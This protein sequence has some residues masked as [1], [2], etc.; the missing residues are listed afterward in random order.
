MAAPTQ[1]GASG[2][3]DGATGKVGGLKDLRAYVERFDKDG[4][5]YYRA[6]FAGFG[7]QKA[8]MTMCSQLKKAKVSCLAMQG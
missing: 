1:N 2:L 3:L 4:Q 8:A 7:S 5:S 6:R